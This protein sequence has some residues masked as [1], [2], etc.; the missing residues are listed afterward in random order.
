MPLYIINDNITHK[1]ADVRVSINENMLSSCGFPFRLEFHTDRHFDL[2]DGLQ[3]IVSNTE[4]LLSS[5]DEREKLELFYRELLLNLMDYAQD[6]MEI[7]LLWSY[8]STLPIEQCMDIA[9]HA[10]QDFLEC[11]DYQVYLVVPFDKKHLVPDSVYPDIE[12]F[13]SQKYVEGKD[14]QISSI[15]SNGFVYSILRNEENVGTD[16][17]I[18]LNS[19]D[20]LMG[21]MEDP[22]AQQLFRMIDERNLTDVEVYKGAM[23]DRKLFSKIRKGNGY[24][25]RKDTILALALSMKLNLDETQDLLRSAGYT[26][27]DSSKMDLIIGYF[28]DHRE[29]DFFKINEALYNFGIPELGIPRN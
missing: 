25:P 6:S 23:I 29:Y 5:H 28:I 24:T 11:Y 7:P 8:Q 14:F 10:I 2:S 27:S 21:R 19:L 3:I 13:I 16:E 22:F 1:K 9:R 12:S 20:E 15:H 18:R 26:L 4:L 17:L